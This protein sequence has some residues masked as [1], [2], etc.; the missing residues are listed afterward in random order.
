MEGQG[1]PRHIAFRFFEASRRQPGALRAF[2]D[3]GGPRAP[4]RAREAAA[5]EDLQHGDLRNGRRVALMGSGFWRFEKS[6]DPQETCFGTRQKGG[7]GWCRQNL[8]AA[9]QSPRGS[10]ETGGFSKCFVYV[11]LPF[12]AALRTVPCS[13]TVV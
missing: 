7:E 13:D 8:N 1:V 9:F 12:K 6:R 2:G 10:V 4:Q 11:G 3:G 5:R